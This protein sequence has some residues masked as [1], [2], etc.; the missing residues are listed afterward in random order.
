M[1][2]EQY[3][4]MI[5]GIFGIALQLVLKYAPKVSDWYMNHAQKGLIA[6][7][8]SVVIGGAY[9]ALAC[10]PYAAQLHI[11]LTCT[12]DSVFSLLQAIFIIASTQQLTYLYTRG[13]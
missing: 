2:P 7:G 1:T 9:L 11:A 6:L 4:A 3:A 8:F 13:K 10:S 5:L 12:E